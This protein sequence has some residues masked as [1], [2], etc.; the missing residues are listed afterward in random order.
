MED[1]LDPPEESQPSF[2]TGTVT[3]LFTDI[4]GSTRL[5]ERHPQGMQ[6]AVSSHN[7]ILQQ[8]IREN[9][10]RVFEFITDVILSGTSQI[11]CNS[12]VLTSNKTGLCFKGY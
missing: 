2:P 3:F 11:M 9:G 7:T 4:K 5:W 1:T 6:A 12:H 8:A 10:V